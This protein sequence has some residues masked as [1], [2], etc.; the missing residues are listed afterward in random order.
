M[1]RFDFHI[2]TTASPDG[3]STPEQLAHAA[4]A[5]G[6]IHI[7][8]T[9]HYEAQP[10]DPALF[11]GG[12][13]KPWLEAAADRYEAVT[14]LSWENT[15]TVRHLTAGK[16]SVVFGLELG[17]PLDDRAR[18]E[19]LIA[20]R[21]YDFLLA[22]QHANPGKP[23]W[24]YLQSC[25]DF[26]IKGE[27]AAYFDALLDIVAWGKFH[28]LAHITYPF[29]YIPA[30][31]LAELSAV[32]I[33]KADAVLRGLAENGLALEINT[34]GLRKPIGETSPTLPLVKR[35]K[36]LGGEFVTIGSDAHRPDEVGSGLDVAAAIAA[37]AG[38]RYITRYE[39]GKPIPERIK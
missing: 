14:A 38:F 15:E 37:D 22:S 3:H 20:R 8:I 32:W 27:L 2:H 23:D 30:E 36:Q 28:S 21:P 10:A 35:F 9:D 12:N 7:A 19:E 25:P 4:M 17:S 18:T 16:V 6:L 31:R 26:D 1:K 29:R 34:G 24:Y 33:D 39:Q 11:P 5:A 13:S